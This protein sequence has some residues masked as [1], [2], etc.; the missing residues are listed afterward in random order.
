MSGGN[1]SNHNITI[2]MPLSLTSHS[3][4]DPSHSLPGL[5]ITDTHSLHSGAMRQASVGL[6]TISAENVMNNPRTRDRVQS[7]DLQNSI[8][9][10]R[11][12]GLLGGL[13]IFSPRRRRIAR[14]ENEDKN[15]GN[16][17]NNNS[18]GRNNDKN[19]K[20]MKN[21]QNGRKYSTGM[22][23]HGGINHVPI[24]Y[25]CGPYALDF[26][27]V[28]AENEIDNTIRHVLRQSLINNQHEETASVISDPMNFDK[29][30]RSSMFNIVRKNKNKNKNSNQNKNNNK[31][32]NNNNN[33][34]KNN[35][36]LTNTEK[37]KNLVRQSKRNIISKNNTDDNKYQPIRDRDIS[38]A[39][40][41]SLP[42]DAEDMNDDSKW[43]ELP[44]RTPGNSTTS[45]NNNSPNYQSDGSLGGTGVASG[46]DSSFSPSAKRGKQDYKSIST[47]YSSS[48]YGSSSTMTPQPDSL[49]D[50]QGTSSLGTQNHSQ[51]ATDALLLSNKETDISDKGKSKS[52]GKK[53]KKE[54][55]KENEMGVIDGKYARS[56]PEIIKLTN[57]GLR[58][59]SIGALGSHAST[60]G[61]RWD[62]N[63]LYMSLCYENQEL[64][65]SKMADSEMNKYTLNNKYKRIIGCGMAIC[66][67]GCSALIYLPFLQ[68][69]Q[70]VRHRELMLNYVFSFTLGIYVMSTLLILFMGLYKQIFVNDVPW[71]KPIL[72]PAVVS[73]MMYAAGYSS[74]LFA[75]MYLE[76]AFVYVTMLVGSI[77]VSNL[78]SIFYFKE[79]TDRE[80]QK[81]MACGLL[82]MTCGIV[83]ESMAD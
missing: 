15:D 23:N 31:N 43:S 48:G 5:F 20:N 24:S 21:R 30:N 65:V 80:S 53:K 60:T 69:K 49:R 26:T 47:R 57:S 55:E 75:T 11:A 37:L 29:I 1:N 2:G 33:N 4:G 7:I 58:D 18:N 74:F 81:Y 67:G 17:N 79:I 32:K 27:T 76:Y 66:Q 71:Q 61:E 36:Q 44:T 38:M 45:Y 46:N 73:G 19:G 28:A 56:E 78:W 13:R 3:R 25:Y 39:N 40:P 54:T 70:K 83:L 64:A 42:E 14:N 10:G 9:L 8:A 82:L 35:K 68:W 22:I 59:R 51:R 62:A 16:N 41:N 63:E 34:N 77:I 52:K 6:N 12:Q 50:R 72:R